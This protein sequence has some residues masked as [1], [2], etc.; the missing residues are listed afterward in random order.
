MKVANGRIIFQAEPE[1]TT[2]NGVILVYE[3]KEN[4]KGKVVAVGDDVEDV[5]VGD[6]VLMNRGHAR[7]IEDDL[8]SAL[9]NPDRIV[10]YG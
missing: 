7:H 2:K 6:N 5:S 4:I 9:M 8:Y 3:L 10:V 1:A